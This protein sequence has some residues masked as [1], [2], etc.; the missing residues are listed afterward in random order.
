MTML[1]APQYLCDTNIWVKICLGG[2]CEK[3]FE[4]YSGMS[5][6]DFVENE[7]IKWKANDTRFSKIGAY[8]ESLSDSY[9]VIRLSDLSLV[10]RS[11]ILK[12]FKRYFGVSEVDNT[13]QKIPNLGEQG[14]LLY[15][16]HLGIPYIQSDDNEFFQN[17]KIREYFEDIE[18][19]TWSDVAE[20]I[21]DN[22]TE[23]IKL[24]KG[25]EQEQEIMNNKRET[26]KNDINKKNSE[27]IGELK[28]F[29]SSRNAS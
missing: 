6:A 5:F 1:E 15:A 10:T 22:D 11:L 18:V 26:H 17:Q 3:F 4:V 24:N 21:T 23:R 16:Y 13:K 27:R 9:N 29:F 28:K 19:L 14:S 8:Y 20:E 7:I 25:I 12:D 2:K